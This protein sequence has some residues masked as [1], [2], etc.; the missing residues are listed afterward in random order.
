VPQPSTDPNDIVL[1]MLYAVA[2]G[3]DQNMGT[4][5]AA[6]GMCNT[7]TDVTQGGM[8]SLLII[9][10]WRVGV[11]LT[12]AR[13]LRWDVTALT[14]VVRL[15]TKSAERHP[16]GASGTPGPRRRARLWHQEGRVMVTAQRSPQQDEQLVGERQARLRQRLRCFFPRSCSRCLASSVAR[17]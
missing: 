5:Q 7:D 16:P 10:P 12:L 6:N 2:K 13:R 8:G 1:T 17:C 14:P 9:A 15:H 4:F 11:L 3:M